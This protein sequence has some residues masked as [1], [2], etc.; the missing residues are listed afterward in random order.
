MIDPSLLTVNKK[1]SSKVIFIYVIPELCKA[2][3]N[4]SF[5]SLL[6]GYKTTLTDPGYYSLLV[7]K[8]NSFSLFDNNILLIVLFVIILLGSKAYNFF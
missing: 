7:A 5:G 6:N 4:I 2:I 3:S 8:K 1:L